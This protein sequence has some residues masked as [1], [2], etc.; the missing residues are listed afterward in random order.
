MYSQEPLE[1]CFVK[2]RQCKKVTLQPY[3]NYKILDLP[4]AAFN[5]FT[6]A[7]LPYQLS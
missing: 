7:D 5:L 2:G 6:V 3:G 4:T 1:N